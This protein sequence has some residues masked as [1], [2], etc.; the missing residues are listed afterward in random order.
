M[1]RV[2]L[3]ISISQ[4]QDRIEGKLVEAIHFPLPNKWAGK[5]ITIRRIYESHSNIRQY[6]TKINYVGLRRLHSL[7]LWNCRLEPRISRRQK[8][9]SENAT[10]QRTDWIETRR[11]QTMKLSG[12]RNQLAEKV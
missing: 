6:I 5:T 10:D 3:E 1:K 12:M 8:Q 7:D 4:I 11:R 2:F 9:G